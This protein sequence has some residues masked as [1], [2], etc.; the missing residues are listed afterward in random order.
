[1]WKLLE[2]QNI[3]LNNRKKQKNRGFSEAK[4]VT[5]YSSKYFISISVYSNFIGFFYLTFISLELL[6]YQRLLQF[7]I[8][9]LIYMPEITHFVWSGC[10][11]QRAPKG[12]SFKL[13]TGP[14]GWSPPGG[15]PNMNI[16]LVGYIRS[17]LK[18]L[19]AR[20]VVDMSPAEMK[21]GTGSSE[22]SVK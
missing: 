19:A 8:Y 12:S 2:S 4:L 17:D 13:V 6:F 16:P 1:M 10:C 21:P 3:S 18:L 11:I 14:L 7:C 20:Q 5:A 15:N 9:F 22:R